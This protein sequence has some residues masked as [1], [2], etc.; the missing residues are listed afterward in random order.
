M[1]DATHRDLAGRI[2][3]ICPPRSWTTGVVVTALVIGS[4]VA[5][6]VGAQEP[7][8]EVDVHTSASYAFSGY[9]PNAFPETD[10]SLNRDGEVRGVDGVATASESLSATTAPLHFHAEAAGSV[11]LAA[12]TMGV[13]SAISA[14]TYDGTGTALSSARGGAWVVDTITLSEPA[15]VEFRG[16]FEGV[17]TASVNNLEY[18]GYPRGYASF[19][20][21]FRSVEDDCSGEACEPVAVY[22]QIGLEGPYTIDDGDPVGTAPTWQPFS[23]AIGLPAGVTRLDVGMTAELSLD[24]WGYDDMTLTSAARLDFGSTTLFE[25]V[26]PDGVTVSS[27]SGL[28]PIVG[29]T[30]PVEDTTPPTVTFDDTGDY[31]PNG[32]NGWFKA[33]GN[34]RVK[35]TTTDDLSGIATLTCTDASDQAVDLFAPGSNPTSQWGEIVLATT[36][37]DGEHVFAC[38]ATDTSG[39]TSASASHTLKVDVTPPTVSILGVIEGASYP[40]A[41]P[42]TVTCETTD[43]TSGTATAASLEP[44]DLSTSGAKTATCSGAVD[45]AGNPQYA[46]VEIH[47]TVTAPP[48]DI[49]YTAAFGQPLS[50]D[51]AL[52]KTKLGR[53]VPVKV[54]LIGSDGSEDRIGPVS[55]Q[56]KKLSCTAGGDVNV[57]EEYVAAGTSNTSNQFR[58]DSADDH[59]IFNLDTSKLGA[60]VGDCVQLDVFRGGFTSQT[61]TVTGGTLIGN[62][63]LTFTK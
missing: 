35:V 46:T 59:W 36:S 27:G 33:E 21:K 1:A 62:V 5:G 8:D 58:W 32:D 14:T 42:P 63:K 19:D 25:I 49:S 24:Q 30:G 31:A 10:G 12:G 18:G 39:N 16:T 28:L 2:R 50:G 40:L 53:V 6:P 17:T 51:G 15:I 26:V 22:G 57:V 37:S 34:P 29:G 38:T 7:Q 11:D 13:V 61:G 52:N 60:K 3:T 4:A 43:A 23:E 20:A 54:E 47:F 45:N 48:D 44:L 9:T 56:T 55:F 41:S